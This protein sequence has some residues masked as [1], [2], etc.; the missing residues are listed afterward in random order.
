MATAG[1]K[2]GRVR[3]TRPARV[4]SFMTSEGRKPGIGIC[5]SL[6]AWLI[7][8]PQ[9]PTRAQTAV[10]GTGFSTLAVQSTWWP[11]E[12]VPPVEVGAACSLDEV[13]EGREPL[14]CGLCRTS[15]DFTAAESLTHESIDKHGSPS[16]P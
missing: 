3:N 7:F 12:R 11:P 10:E 6:G 13:T 9:R 15:I 8:F 16:A 2:R 5:W 4:K 1:Q 14:P